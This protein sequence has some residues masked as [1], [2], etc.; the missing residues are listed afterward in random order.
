MWT[1]NAPRKSG[2]GH[3]AVKLYSKDKLWTRDCIVHPDVDEWK[4]P[5]ALIGCNAGLLAYSTWQE[6]MQ[7]SLVYVPRSLCVRVSN[8]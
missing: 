5:D 3:L 1:Y 7:C 2:G 6:P 8:V 4:Y